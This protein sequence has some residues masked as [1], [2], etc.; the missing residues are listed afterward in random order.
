MNE[1]LVLQSISL[2]HLYQFEEM[3]ERRV[4]TTIRGKSH[5][6]ELLIVL[7][8]I[9]IGSL[10]L[11]IVFNGAILAGTVDFH[12]VLINNATSTDIEMPHL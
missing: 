1:G 5:E 8:G 6:V 9:G 10:H 3:I 11:R 7:L 4:H 2:A 12:Q